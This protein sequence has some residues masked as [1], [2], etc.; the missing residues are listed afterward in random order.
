VP[1]SPT[2]PLTVAN[3]VVHFQHHP[4]DGPVLPH[5]VDRPTKLLALRAS[6]GARLAELPLSD[7]YSSG[8]V[9][10][11][12][13]RVFVTAYLTAVLGFAPRVSSSPRP[14]RPG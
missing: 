6:T 13:G 4:V 12:P 10:V 7:G 14:G 3:G 11:G 1:A 9:A 8:T 5:P 2:G